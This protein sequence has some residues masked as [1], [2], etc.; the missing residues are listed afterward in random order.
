MLAAWLIPAEHPVN[1]D[2]AH[3]YKA[4]ISRINKTNEAKQRKDKSNPRD[5]NKDFRK[6][7]EIK[8]C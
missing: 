3:V 7:L 4:Q 6:S 8:N 2:R 5:K 1:I